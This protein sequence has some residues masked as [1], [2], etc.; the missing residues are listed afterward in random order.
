MMSEDIQS[1]SLCESAIA[2]AFNECIA[3]IY[4]NHDIA[5]LL[6]NLCIDCEIVSK[7]I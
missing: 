5:N 7:L 6:Y 3:Q 2:I 4:Y 1:F